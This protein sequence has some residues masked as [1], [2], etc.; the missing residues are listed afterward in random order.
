MP[1]A[2]AAFPNDLGFTDT[3]VGNVAAPTS[4]SFTSGG[5]MLV[6]TQAGAVRVFVNGALQATPALTL[7]GVCSSGEQGL[8][9]SAVTASNEV[10][11]YYTSSHDGDCW[12]R[13]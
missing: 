13:V 6:T 1:P 12:N 7:S 2:G 9:G 10:F 5:R 8:L 11:L 3:L 4:I